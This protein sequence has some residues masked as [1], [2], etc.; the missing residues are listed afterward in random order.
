MYTY[1]PGKL[2]CLICSQFLKHHKILLWVLYFF[3]VLWQIQ[4]N[5]FTDAL[6]MAFSS[7]V[8]P[9]LW[10]CL[11]LRSCFLVWLKFNNWKNDTHSYLENVF[12][13]E[14]INDTYFQTSCTQ[15]QGHFLVSGN[16][17][18]WG[19]FFFS[20]HLLC[21]RCFEWSLLP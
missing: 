8:I 12:S 21:L 6:E 10:S 2:Y 3:S 20:S 15:N 9:D 18:T 19:L 17:N 1:K 4:C 16:V 5:I 14:I 13:F 11:L 7:C